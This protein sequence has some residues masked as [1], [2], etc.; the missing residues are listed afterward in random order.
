MKQVK[1]RIKTGSIFYKGDFKKLQ[2][3]VESSPRYEF[4]LQIYIVQPGLSI[5]Q[6]SAKSSTLLATASRGLV[7]N[8]CKRLQVICAA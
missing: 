1:S 7:A 8:G 5:S 4:P 3:F 2:D 6:L